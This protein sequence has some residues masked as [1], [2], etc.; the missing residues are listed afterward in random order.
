[1]IHTRR[2]E[3][4]AERVATEVRAAGAEA[5]IVLA[6]LAQTEAAGAVVRA[7][8]ARFGRLDVLIS[9]AGFADRSRAAP[10]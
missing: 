4:G 7:A 3:A 9:N 8:I 1:M 5:D 2:N 6:D 10:L